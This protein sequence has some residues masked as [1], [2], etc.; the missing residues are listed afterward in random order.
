MKP[1]KTDFNAFEW[2][3]PR[4]FKEINGYEYEATLLSPKEK[5]QRAWRA[6]R[7][8]INIMLGTFILITSITYAYSD[9]KMHKDNQGRW[10][11][12]QGG[13]IYGDSRF[14][15]DAD[16]RFNLS[17]DPRFNMDADP[18]FNLNADPRF[19]MNADPR[20]NINGAR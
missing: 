5:R 4:S 9:S 17:A 6:T 7:M 2:R 20:F 16:P 3:F 15:L 1:V 11:N 10:V 12:A 19:N 8:S 14:N 13:N 18:R